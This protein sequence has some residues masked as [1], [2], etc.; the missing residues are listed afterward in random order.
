M[1]DLKTVPKGS[2]LELKHHGRGKQEKSGQAQ[3]HTSPDS[4]ASQGN[5][6]TKLSQ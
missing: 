3:L 2:M 5:I 6:W 1:I 4:G